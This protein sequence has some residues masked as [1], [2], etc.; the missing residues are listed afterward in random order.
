MRVWSINVR[1]LLYAGILFLFLES[2]SKKDQPAHSTDTTLKSF[3]LIP[4][5]DL[6]HVDFV[7]HRI[8]V[9]VPETYTSGSALTASFT[10][11]EG[12]ALTVRGVP[13]QSGVTKNNFETEVSYTL[14][15]A[16]QRTRM[17][18][19]VEATN[20]DHSIDWGMGHF[21][22]RSYSETRHYNWYIDQS[23]SG[24]FA[25]VNC[26]PASVTMAIRWSDSGFTK[27][28]QEARNMFRS[29]GGWWFT[30]DINAYLDM[31]NVTHAIIGLS[32]N[33]DSTQSILTHQ[34]DRHQI[35]ILCLD[36][37]F[38]R[39]A[40]NG[41][42]RTDKFYPTTPDWGHFIV[43]KGYRKVDGELFFEAYDPFSFGLLNTDQTLKGLDR[44]YRYEDLAAACLPWWNFAF[45]I[46]KKGANLDVD[47]S[48]RKLNPLQV[49]EAHNRNN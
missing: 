42:Y 7:K 25:P 39:S 4:G 34:L 12:A 43:L 27:T 32:A 18:W 23:T 40:S 49:P 10:I 22:N 47:A 9:R 28:A 26:G 8:S 13:Q 33:R 46:A 24:A 1:I 30:S 35:I 29:D 20:N 14:T 3:S 15:A 41:D 31:Y 5:Q 44:Y 6:T 21:I 2:C 36:M 48:R 11:P 19:A 17:D 45:V 16:D 38:V 37:N